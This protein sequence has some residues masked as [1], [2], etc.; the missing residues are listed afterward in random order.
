MDDVDAARVLRRRLDEFRRAT[1]LPLAFG[2]LV[3]TDGRLRLSQFSGAHSGALTGL[4]VEVCTGLG[5]RAMASGRTH[6]VTDYGSARSIT[7]D[8]DHA[9]VARERLTA[10]FA[11]PVPVGGRVVAVLYGATRSGGFGD[12]ALGHG[13]ATA[14]AVA[15]DLRVDVP[16]PVVVDSAA[17]AVRVLDTLLRH[18]TDPRV[19][20]RV[21]A[22]RI[23]LGR[24]LASPGDVGMPS[25]RELDVLR[26]VALGR[27]NAEI[28]DTLGLSAHTV[29]AYLSSAMRKLDT[30]TRT[31]AAHVA[32]TAGL[33]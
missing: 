28:A 3:G 24:G 13:A 15:D 4:R 2:G 31:A 14:R 32:R 27:T 7:H 16:G 20:H 23:Y 21:G 10:V 12:V 6:A 19:R 26:L 29:K 1:C 11:T 17:D 18:V 5:G 8:Y 25:T 9:V 33:L 30:R 22:V